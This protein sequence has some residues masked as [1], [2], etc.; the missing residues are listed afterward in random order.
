MS[1]Q[2]VIK[3]TMDEVCAALRAHGISPADCLMVKERES[4]FCEIRK[5]EEC[6]ATVRQ[7]CEPGVLRWFQEPPFDPPFPVGTLLHYQIEEEPS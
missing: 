2:L 1:I 4:R 6:L 5:Q 7:E 3:G